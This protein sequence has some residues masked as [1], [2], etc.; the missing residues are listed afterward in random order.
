MR[1]R[2][3][4]H[5]RPIEMPYFDQSRFPVGHGTAVSELVPWMQGRADWLDREAGFPAEEI[6]RLRQVGALSPPLPAQGLGTA[7]ELAALLILVGQ[8]NLSVGRILEAHVNARHLIARYGTPREDGRLYGLWVTDPPRNG[9][10]MRRIGGKVVLSGGKQFCS[11][12]GHATGAVVTAQDEDGATRMLVLPLG[13]GEVVKPLPSPLQGMR[14]A[15]T[16]A[17]DFSGCEV[18]MGRCARGS[19]GLPAGARFFRWGMA[20]ICGG[21]RWPDCAAGPRCFA[22]EGLRAARQSTYAGAAWTGL[23]CSREQP[24]VGIRYGANC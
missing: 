18:R 21:A 23:Y 2:C 11:A 14:A 13:I 20:R 10:Q 5:L 19:G 24:P 17:V 6:E 12:A 8:S 7:D 1:L 16:G 15:V 4:K 22:A 9:L 3:P